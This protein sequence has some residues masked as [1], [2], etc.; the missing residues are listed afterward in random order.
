MAAGETTAQARRKEEKGRE[1]KE[2][3]KRNGRGEWRQQ[4][5]DK[6]LTKER[7]RTEAATMNKTTTR[8]VCI[9]QRG[10]QARASICPATFAAADDASNTSAIR[11]Q[12]G[13]TS[14]HTNSMCDF[15]L[16]RTPT[17]P[18]FRV[19][20]RA[21]KRTAYCF[22]SAASSSDRRVC[23]LCRVF[24]FDA[25]Y[26]WDY[27]RWRRSEILWRDSSQLE[28]I[29]ENCGFLALTFITRGIRVDSL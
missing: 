1:R 10:R 23:Q 20:Q 3:R 28:Y 6:R 13:W 17:E 21:V 5:W 4:A 12:I 7:W 16:K 27:Q 18:S 25:I 8:M 29:E 22:H 15:L 2:G 11:W 9:M 19:S 26:F 14:M 24:E